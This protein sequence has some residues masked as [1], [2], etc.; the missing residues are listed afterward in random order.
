MKR[1]F[2]FLLALALLPVV[3]LA[4]PGV[5]LCYRMNHYAAAYNEN[6]PGYFDYDSLIIDLYFMDDFSTAYYCKTTWADGAVETTGY[7]LCTVSAKNPDG[8]R[9]LTFPNGENMSFFYEDGELWLSMQN[10]T[11][12]LREFDELFDVNKDLR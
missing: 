5:C 3:S 6:H 12:H 9:L 7:V 10:G 1:F 4:D 2:C 8:T 11:Y